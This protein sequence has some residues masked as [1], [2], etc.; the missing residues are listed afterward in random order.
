VLRLLRWIPWRRA[1]IAYL[2]MLVTASGHQVI[3][4]AVVPAVREE[5]GRVAAPAV[6]IA[7]MLITYFLTVAAHEAGHAVGAAWA[8]LAVRCVRIGPFGITRRGRRWVT[9]WDG[10]HTHLEGWVD[11]CGLELAPRR[12]AAVVFLAGPM[13][14]LVLGLAAAVVAEGGL[15]PVPACWLRMFAVQSLLFGA[16]NLVPQRAG[17]FE[18]DGLVL[19]RLLRGGEL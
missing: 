9:R 8:G 4:P 11:C 15:P 1:A 5:C 3:W 2:M 13:A 7:G 19:C 12:Y 10:W 18:T 14:S 6:F 16:I 17:E